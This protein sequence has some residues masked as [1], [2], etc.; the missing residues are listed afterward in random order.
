M[1]GRRG[2]V[3]YFPSKHGYFTTFQGRTY[4]LAEGPED[5]PRGPTFLAALDE[6]KRILREATVGTA[7]DNNMVQTIIGRF[8]QWLEPRRKK[9]T[10][11]IHRDNL[12]RFCQ[13]SD[14]GSSPFGELRVGELLPYH[15]ER[16]CDFMR[17]PRWN[18][19]SKKTVRWT[20][21]AVRC[22]LISLN[23]Q[24]ELILAC[25]LSVLT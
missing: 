18:P 14:E 8:L 16:F 3:R 5:G 9:T 1:R 13:F 4:R 24:G 7:K 22:F 21:G 23:T 6:F 20:S 17:Q 11:R 15:A 10:Y 25:P 19:H 12:E 2:N